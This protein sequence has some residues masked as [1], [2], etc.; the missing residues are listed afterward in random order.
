MI[1]KIQGDIIMA[2]DNFLKGCDPASMPSLDLS[3]TTNLALGVQSQ[4]DES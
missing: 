3:Y 2:N 1:Y 4:I